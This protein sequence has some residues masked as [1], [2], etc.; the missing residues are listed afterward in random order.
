MNSITKLYLHLGKT[1]DPEPERTGRALLL[2]L[3]QSTCALV[4]QQANLSLASLM[5][6]C[7]PGR[8]MTILLNTGLSE[9]P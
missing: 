8:V 9:D 5:Q 3:A 1:M 2:K 6:G 7:N 4:D